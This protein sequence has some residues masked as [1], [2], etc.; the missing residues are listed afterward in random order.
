MKAAQDAQ[1]ASAQALAEARD[2]LADRRDDSTAHGHR[3]AR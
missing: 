1:H 3:M 2:E